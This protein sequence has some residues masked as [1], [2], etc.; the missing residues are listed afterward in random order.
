MPYKDLLKR[1]EYHKKYNA[2][3]QQKKKEHRRLYLKKFYSI[4][5]NREKYRLRLIRWRVKNK[6]KLLIQHRE[7]N[8]KNKEKISERHNKK[9]K[10]L[11]LEILKYYGGNPPKCN[12]CGENEIK[13]LTIDHLDND[14]NKHRKLLKTKNIIRWIRNNNYPPKF[15]ILCFNCNCAKGIWKICPHKK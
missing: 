3:W 8:E 11:R 1:K 4:P 12:C 10:E 7:Y 15:Q 6:D 14:G 5:E 9:N 13:F 2:S